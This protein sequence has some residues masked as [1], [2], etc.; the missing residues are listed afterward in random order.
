M[1]TPTPP[2]V[3]LATVHLLMGSVSGAPVELRCSYS[4]L[5]SEPQAGRRC[6]ARKPPRIKAAPSFTEIREVIFMERL[7]EPEKKRKV[8]KL[9]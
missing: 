1:H 9:Y 7:Q 8:K 5:K 3:L 2:C 6:P 4:I